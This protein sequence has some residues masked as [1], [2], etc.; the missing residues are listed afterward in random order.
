M[1]PREILKKIRPSELRTNRLVTGSAFGA[2]ASAR[3]TVRQPA[4]SNLNSPPNSVRMLKRRERRAPAHFAA[5]IQLVS[6][7]ALTC[8][9][10]PRRGFQPAAL[11]DHLADRSNNPVAGCSKDAVSVSPSPWGEGRDEG[12]RETNFDSNCCHALRLG[13]RPQPRSDALCHSSPQFRRIPRAIENRNDADVV[14][15]DVKVDAVTMKPFEQ[16]RLAGFPAGKSKAFGVFQNCFDGMIDFSLKPIA[17]AGLLFII[18]K[19]R[20]VEFKASGG[21]E[22]D[23][24]RHAARRAFNFCRASART[25]SQGM[26]RSGCCRSSSARRSSSSFCSCESSSSKSPN[27][28]SMVSTRSRRSASG[29]RRSSSRISVA[30]MPA[31]YPFDL[32]AQAGVFQSATGNRQS[33]IS[34]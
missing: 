19:N 15:V 8:V 26:P 13:L 18:P 5:G 22:N 1:I 6:L 24:A 33:K 27:S 17:Q 20:F 23:F 7:S 31:I 12:G 30:L 11:L 10:S 25:C 14:S 29:I 21:Q 3:F 28:V 16:S 4:A 32:P 2:R 9:L 34:P